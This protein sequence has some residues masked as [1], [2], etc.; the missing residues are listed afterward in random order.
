MTNSWYHFIANKGR[1]PT[2]YNSGFGIYENVDFEFE[3]D[4]PVS[5]TLPIQFSE[6]D[7]ISRPPPTTLETLKTFEGVGANVANNHQNHQHVIEFAGSTT[8]RKLILNVPKTLF[9]FVEGWDNKLSS[10]STNKILVYTFL[11]YTPQHFPNIS[12][13]SPDNTKYTKSFMYIL[14]LL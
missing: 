8:S 3:S 7:T 6:H 14:I 9:L 10:R 4:Q 12:L 1:G 5:C 11:T 13:V 2:S